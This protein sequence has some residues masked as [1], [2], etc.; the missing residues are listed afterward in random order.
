M[1]ES[2]G[3]ELIERRLAFCSNGLSGPRKKMALTYDSARAHRR[4][5]QDEGNA[6]SRRRL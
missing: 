5:K 6:A 1:T 3:S 4:S 2:I